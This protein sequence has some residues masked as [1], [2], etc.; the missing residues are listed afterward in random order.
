MKQ[1]TDDDGVPARRVLAVYNS[2]LMRSPPNLPNPPTLHP[3]PKATTTTSDRNSNRLNQEAGTDSG[4]T[5]DK[6]PQIDA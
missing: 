2:F 4:L 6:P 1:I 5:L 3:Q